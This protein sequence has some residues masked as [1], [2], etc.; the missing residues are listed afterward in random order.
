MVAWLNR[1]SPA[2]TL[3]MAL[4]AIKLA[5]VLGMNPADEFHGDE[6]SYV[7]KARYFRLYGAFPVVE[8]AD[9]AK[10]SLVYSDF[11]PPGY[12]VFVSV[13]VPFARSNAQLRQLV[14]LA[15]FWM[16]AATTALLLFVA[17][18]FHR[19]MS[20]HLASAFI[21]GIQPWTS[22]YVTA[23]YPDTLTAFLTVAGILGLAWFGGTGDR[24]GRPLALLWGSTC[25]ALTF[26]VRPEMIVIVPVLVLIAMSQALHRQPWQRYVLYGLLS[27]VPYLVSVGVN[28]A[29]R[30]QV[31]RQLR[32]YGEFIHATPG[33]DRWVQ[34]WIGTQTLKEELQFGGLT[35]AR[36]SPARFAQMPAHAFVND[37]ERS[38][39]SE[40]VRNVNERGHMTVE[41]DAVFMK[42]AQSRIDAD[43]W[44]YYL[45]TRLYNTLHLWINMSNAT[46]YLRG[47]ALL[48]REF[49]RV[50]TGG[51]LILKI[52][53][54]LGFVGGAAG[55][56]ARFKQ[57]ASTWHN[58]FLLLGTACVLVRTLMFGFFKNHA[59]FRYALVAWPFVLVVALYGLAHL[60][61]GRERLPAAAQPPGSKDWAAPSADPA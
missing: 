55:L 2:W 10:Q 18:K 33:L 48:P 37:D 31:A 22:A 12:P 46:H 60:W 41:E 52:A 25:L 42:I 44:T 32:I 23:I 3:F 1:I 40:L 45:W 29:Y 54:L 17:C 26:L 36:M 14:R 24:T 57:M 53:I 50:L 27:A 8:N 51:F 9:E 59:E 39:L 56:H 19:A 4:M 49:S 43:P 58:N 34:T 11:R 38:T 7:H 30:W 15:Q 5:L 20:F 21:L 47:F 13:F 35:R 6:P 61:P 16:D 28:I